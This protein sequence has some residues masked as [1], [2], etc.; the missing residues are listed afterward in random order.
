MIPLFKVALDFNQTMPHVEYVLRSGYIGEGDMVK[1]FEQDLASEWGCTKRVISVNSCTSALELA[2]HLIGVKDK[3]VI[4]TPQTCTATNTAIVSRGGIILWADVDQ[5]TGN[6]CP[7]SVDR[8]IARHGT[9]A[10]AAICCVD[11][12][13]TAC[14]YDELKKYGIPV[15][16]DAAHSYLTKYKGQ[17]ISMSGGDYVCFS[18]Q[19]IKHLTSGDGGA[20]IVPDDQVDRA[21]LLRWYGL[22]RESGTSF[23]CVQNIQ[24]AGFKFHMNNI[25]AAIGKA[26]IPTARRAVE[27]S[28]ENALYYC[29]NIKTEGRVIYIPLFDPESSYWLY[30]I[31]VEDRD[32]FIAYLGE[33]GVAASP[34]HARND[35]HT[36]FPPRQVGGL[37]RAGVDYFSQYNVSIP[38]GFWLTAEDREKILALVNGW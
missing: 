23:R 35:R 6:I 2:F 34:V 15:V 8:L 19:A 29:E 24:E 10:I 5:F 18:F 21:R 1:A 26:N 16:E 27:A 31:L 3:Y 13:G 14:D 30:T 11:W 17:H 38:N 28:R 33:N 4:T 12:G 7:K 22:D 32:D 25:A 9:A 20:L 37:D 36:C